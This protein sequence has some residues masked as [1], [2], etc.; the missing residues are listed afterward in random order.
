MSVYKSMM[1]GLTEAV[2]HQQGKRK[3]R[4]VKITYTPPHKFQAGEIKEIRQNT[5]LSQVMFAA[6]I[7]VSPKTVEAWERGRNTPEGP[8]SRLLEIVRD[9][10]KFLS[11]FQKDAE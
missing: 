6:S 10:P 9:D 7:G 3:A 11:R 1:K 2:D 5:G 4:S 8:S